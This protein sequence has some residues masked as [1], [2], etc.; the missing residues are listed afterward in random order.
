MTGIVCLVIIFLFRPKP[1]IVNKQAEALQPPETSASPVLEI[2]N[3]STNAIMRSSQPTINLPKPKEPLD[4][5]K[6]QSLADWTNAIPKITQWSH[7]REDSSWVAASR[8]TNDYPTLLLAGLNGSGVQFTASLTDV[9]AVGDHVRRIEMHSVW[10]NIEDTKLLGDSLLELMGKDKASF[11]VWCAKVGN[12]WV[13]APL[14][15]SYNAQLPNSDKVCS[16]GTHRTFSNEK[17]WFINFV[18]ADP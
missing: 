17:P 8:D 2:K 12:N 15:D 5:I 13:D 18:I 4:A 7:F 3:A 9:E 14:Y 1:P 16:F 11:D 6:M 10:M